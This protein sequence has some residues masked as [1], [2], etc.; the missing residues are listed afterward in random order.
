MLAN[1]NSRKLRAMQVHF[2]YFEEMRRRLFTD[3]QVLIAYHWRKC[4]KK[5][6]KKQEAAR[7]RKAKLAEQK[8]RSPYGVAPPATRPKPKAPV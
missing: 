7:K 4:L 5:K 8:K 3:S 1:L 2:D 6:R